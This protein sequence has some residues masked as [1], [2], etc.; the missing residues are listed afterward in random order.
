MKF[1]FSDL[2]FGNIYY[3]DRAGSG[4]GNMP[5]VK[6]RLDDSLDDSSKVTFSDL[7]QIALSL[8]VSCKDSLLQVFDYTDEY[9]CWMPLKFIGKEFLFIVF[10]LLNVIGK[11]Q[12][13]IDE[14]FKNVESKDFYEGEMKKKE[15]QY[16]K[17]FERCEALEKLVTSMDREVELSNELKNLQ[18]E[19]DKTFVEIET[20]RQELGFSKNGD[21]VDL[22]EYDEMPELCSVP[23]MTLKE[24]NEIELMNR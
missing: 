13:F 16:K 11:Q 9:N 4:S 24:L 10:Q 18:T 3:D 7:K 6:V 15:E 20:L 19:Y 8:P 17:L 23:E 1:S 2:K 14:Q 5:T 21:E 12:K 22:D